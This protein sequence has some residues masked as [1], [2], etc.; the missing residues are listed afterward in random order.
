[1][2]VNLQ[3]QQTGIVKQAKVGFSWTTLFF[4]FFPALF[5][6]DW[7]WALI[8]LLSEI[9]AGS[10]TFGVGSFVLEIVFACLYN[11]FYITDL[12][13]NGFAPSDQNSYNILRNKGFVA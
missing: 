4:T 5:R 2:I 13:N 8:M 6:G 9:V 1:M 7:K 10:F 3:N 12:L 11:K